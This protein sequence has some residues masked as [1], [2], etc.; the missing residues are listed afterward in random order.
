MFG[1]NGRNVYGLHRVMMVDV[2]MIRNYGWRGGGSAA[3]VTAAGV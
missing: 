3:G 2:A 1:G